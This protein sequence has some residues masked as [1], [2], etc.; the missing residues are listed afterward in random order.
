MPTSHS[1]QRFEIFE[2]FN[3]TKPAAGVSRTKQSD[4]L[5][6]VAGVIQTRNNFHKLVL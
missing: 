5:K 4:T 2:S 1:Q 6:P 3:Q